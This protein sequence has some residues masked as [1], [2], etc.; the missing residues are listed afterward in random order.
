VGE[1]RPY[2]SPQWKRLRLAILERDGGRCVDC[3][4]PATMVDHVK[5]WR[6]GG[7][8]FDPSN[9]VAVCRSDNT[10]R[11]YRTGGR[12]GVATVRRTSLTW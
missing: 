9:L 8:W 10:K 11:A 3:G 4:G 1:R 12:S 5:P 6:Q 2:D 7:A